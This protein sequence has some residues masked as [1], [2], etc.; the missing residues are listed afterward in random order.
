MLLV[1]GSLGFFFWKFFDLGSLLQIE[2]NGRL[3]FWLL[4][5]AAMVAIRAGGYILR[6]R[7]LARGAL[8]LLQSFQL[9]FLWE[10]ASAV[11]PSTVGGSA[12]AI[13]LLTK[14]KIKT[15]FSTAIVLVATFLDEVYF[16]VLA[17]VFIAVLGSD[18]LFGTQYSCPGID[19]QMVMGSLRDLALPF[20]IGYGLLIAIT[21]FITIGLFARP[22]IFRSV[23]MAVFRL[24][25][26]RRYRQKAAKI[27]DDI[28]AASG[29]YK[30]ESPAFWTGAAA[31]TFLSWTARYFV[32]NCIFMAF[33]SY[34]H[35]LEIFSRQFVMW[36]IMLIP[37]TPGGSLIAETVFTT[38]MCPYI[39]LALLPVLLLVWRML[40]YLPYLLIGPLVLPFWM[41]RVNSVP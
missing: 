15:G 37:A 40:T 33:G 6:L 26:L 29:I 3:V 36:V 34:G 9:I 23:L 20:Y 35:A 5:A 10:Y 8:N 30:R 22:G 7:I 24:P 14:E 17:P 32:L 19:E 28:Q 31:C 41:R 12:V 21:L 27:S 4:L 39:G 13:Y 2:L 18:V 11:T 1:I 16:I 38:Q 25:L